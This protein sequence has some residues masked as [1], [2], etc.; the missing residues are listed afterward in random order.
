MISINP[1][2]YRITSSSIA[3]LSTIPLDIL[4]TKILSNQNVEFKFEEIKWLTILPL[5]FTIQ[6]SVYNWKIL[7]KNKLIRASCAAISASVP[8]ILIEIKKLELK[9]Q[10]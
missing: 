6:N 3:G 10:T 4:Q 5:V 8:Y 9:K 7:P 1:L 2:L